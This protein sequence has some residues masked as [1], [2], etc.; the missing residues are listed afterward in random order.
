MYVIR[1]YIQREILI[2]PNGQSELYRKTYDNLKKLH[3]IISD[4][5]L[6]DI[7]QL[8]EPKAP[9][10]EL[11][12]VSLNSTVKTEP[13]HDIGANPRPDFSMSTMISRTRA[14]T[15]PDKY[16]QRK[17][18]PMMQPAM[19]ASP[20]FPMYNGQS[21]SMSQGPS[22]Y[23]DANSMELQQPTESIGSARSMQYPPSVIFP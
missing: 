14:P 11:K 10:E 21:P 13:M 22:R 9:N 19:Q 3:G 17:S 6:H 18:G 4:I 20:Q 16:M 15:A 5:N 2:A 8:P 1:A 12:G 7:D 23:Q